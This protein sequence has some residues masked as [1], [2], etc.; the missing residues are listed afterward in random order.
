MHVTNVLGTSPDLWTPENDITVPSIQG[1]AGAPAQVSAGFD[2][3]RPAT[4]PPDLPSLLLDSRIVYV[5]MPVR[6]P[7]WIMANE[8]RT[9]HNCASCVGWLLALYTLHSLN[10]CRRGS[11]EHLLSTIKTNNFMWFDTVGS[12]G[13]RTDHC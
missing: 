5:G 8:T 7:I 4:P 6:Q 12:S 2:D 13:N 11:F 10:C 9:M 3:H 1:V